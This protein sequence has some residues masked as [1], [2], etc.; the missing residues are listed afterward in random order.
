MWYGPAMEPRGWTTTNL[1]IGASIAIAGLFGM[2]GFSRNTWWWWLAW[3]FLL[4][5]LVQILFALVRHGLDTRS[6][7]GS[8]STS[9]ARIRDLKEHIADLRLIAC[10]EARHLLPSI[11]ME[12]ALI[13]QWAYWLRRKTPPRVYREDLEPPDVVS[14]R[15][16]L[17]AAAEHGELPYIK[18][19]DETFTVTRGDL[20]EFYKRPPYKIR[21]LSKDGK[22]VAS[23]DIEL[24]PNTLPDFY[25]A[26][27]W[28]MAHE[29]VEAMKRDGIRVRQHGS[30]TWVHIPPGDLEINIERS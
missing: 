26:S 14:L 19:A 10:G 5:G 9:E 7:K 16:V 21:I 11:D 15:R 13:W 4:A 8:P 29:T 3:A 23:E 20:D 30:K 12:S 2:A 28:E 1:S 27:T 24:P 18:N 17:R 6:R 22:P 25:G